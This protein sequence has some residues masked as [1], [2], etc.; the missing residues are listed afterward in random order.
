[1]LGRY[2]PFFAWAF[3]W[4]PG[5]NFFRRPV[6]GSF[7]FV[8]M[9]AILAGHLLADYVRDGLP[10]RRIFAATVAVAAALAIIAWAVI[11]SARSGHAGSATIEALRMAPIPLIVIVVLALARTA[12]ARRRAAAAVTLIAVAELVYWNGISRLNAE[13]RRHYAVLEQPADADAAALDLLERAIRERQRN[14]ERPRVEIMGV[15]GPWQNVAVVRGLE[16]INGYN[17]LR[18]G[19]YDRLIAPGETTYLS[20]QRVFPASFDGYDCALARALGLEY[21]VLDRPIERVPHL[22]RRPVADLLHGG[23]KLWI[24]RLGNAMP[25]VTFTT[26]FQVADADGLG[27]LGELLV[28]PSSDRVLFDIETPPSEAYWSTAPGQAGRTRIVSWRPDRIEIEA[29]SQL[30]GM[31]ALHETYYPGWIAEV[32]GKRARILRADVLFRGVE[33]PPGRRRV[34]FR[35]APFSFENLANALAAALH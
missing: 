30:G 3:N 12:P 18:I 22:A 21:V 24:Y 28:S 15:G 4:V 35:Y 1:M 23:P 31:L 34:V 27:R 25:R 32:D 29:D 5:V 33:I 11:F 7:V 20:E 13:D 6:D 14:G 19:V 8:A 2:T 16:A 26:R 9:L 10:R 17:P